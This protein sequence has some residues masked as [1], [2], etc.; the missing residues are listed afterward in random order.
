MH[1]L[2][3]PQRFRDTVCLLHV[4]QSTEAHA[5]DETAHSADRQPYGCLSA[6]GI[7][8]DIPGNGGKEWTSDQVRRVGEAS[9]ALS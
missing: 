6:T 2:L 1:G 7:I 3:L 4:S 8:C 5:M 9:G